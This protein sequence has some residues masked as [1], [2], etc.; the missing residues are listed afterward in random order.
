[1]IWCLILKIALVSVQYIG[2]VTGGG[3]IHVIN[4][5]KALVKR[6][7]DVTVLCMGIGDLPQYEVISVNG[8]DIKILRFWTRDSKFLKNP[9]EGS[10]EEEINRLKEFKNKVL[11]FLMKHRNFDVIHLH[12]HFMIPSLA[13]ELR[14]AGYPSK[15]VTTFHAFESI[16][17]TI[18]HYS[19]SSLQ[20][21][22]ISRERDALLNSDVVIFL[23]KHLIGDV[24]KIHGNIV[25]Q[26]NIRIIPNGVDPFVINHEKS[27]EEINHI[28]QELDTSFLLFNINRIDPSKK[29]EFIIKSLPL[30]YE[31]IRKKIGLLVAGKLE[32]RNRPYR[33]KLSEI[34]KAIMNKVKDLKI[35]IEENI[36]DHRKILY[37][38]AAD[39][40]VT[41]SPIEPF[42]MTILESIVREI[43]VVVVDAPG[44]REIFNINR[45]FE[46][47]FIETEAGVMVRFGNEREVINNL[48][49][50]IAYLLK[51]LPKFRKKVKAYK[52]EAL[53]RYSWEFVTDMLYKVYLDP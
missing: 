47:K 48:S 3:G 26:V 10:K 42:G 53:L 38:D 17:E 23:S 43:P 1:M 24:R 45:D 14:E 35:L 28:R 39:A 32:N 19:P 30:T 49:S 40:F 37:Y 8:N 18:K 31:E 50:A 27:S 25:D 2:T 20:S 41:A 11:E 52:K 51:N 4:L 5:S 46:E 9:F 36:S 16:S 33:K 7:L 22:I 21:Y 15:I 13:R 44:P 6:G 34:S 29:I 12:G